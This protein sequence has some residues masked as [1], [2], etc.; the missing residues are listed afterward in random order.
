[1]WLLDP[2]TSKRSV[3]L[4]MLTVSF[5]SIIGCAFAHVLGKLDSTGPLLELFYACSA[6]YF[7]RRFE[8]K[9]DEASIGK[10]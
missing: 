6:L 5:V 8:R 2:K 4:T 1:M 10:E 9:K 7:G 3:S